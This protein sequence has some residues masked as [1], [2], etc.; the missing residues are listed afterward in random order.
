MITLLNN[1]KTLTSMKNILIICILTIG[2]LV[3]CTDK[4]AAQNNDNQLSTQQ[5]KEVEQLEV[6]NQNLDQ[7]HNEI[8][9]SSKELDA[10]LKEI[11]N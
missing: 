6:E 5:I 3:S 7:I 2:A 4:K 1:T 8:Q 11:D 10:L 9:N